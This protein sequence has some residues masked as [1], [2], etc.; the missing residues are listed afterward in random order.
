MV[1]TLRIFYSRLSGCLFVRPVAW[2]VILILWNFPYWINF[3]M[4]FFH[5][6][7]KLKNF[8]FTCFPDFVLHSLLLKMPS[9]VS[10]NIYPCVISLWLWSWQAHCQLYMGRQ[11]GKL[12][13]IYSAA[14][15]SNCI[16]L[17]WPC[18]AC[19]LSLCLK[20]VIWNHLSPFAICWGSNK[21]CWSLCS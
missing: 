13:L 5:I 3:K 16:S 12:C 1:N 8:F 21:C 9:P 4:H 17:L 15:I 14:G 19:R 20:K 2:V 11:E 7:I 18:C 10:S 6:I